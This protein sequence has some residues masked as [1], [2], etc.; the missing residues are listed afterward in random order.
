[1]GAAIVRRHHF[2]VLTLEIALAVLVLD[3]E[4]REVHAV[5]GPYAT[6]PISKTCP[7]ASPLFVPS[8]PSKVNR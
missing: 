1:M 3:P 8:I 4:I 2:D 6:L 5:V 7:T